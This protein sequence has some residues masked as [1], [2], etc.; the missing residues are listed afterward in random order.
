MKGEVVVALVGGEWMR[1]RL[2]WLC[3]VSCSSCS[4]AAAVV[5][6]AVCC[7]CRLFF[8][9][10]SSLI[11]FVFGVDAMFSVDMIG[12]RVKIDQAVMMLYLAIEL[13]VRDNCDRAIELIIFFFPD[14]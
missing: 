9:D 14:L 3:V 10:F 2:A 4:P 1:A 13:C 8:A 6:S 11:F 12:C 5:A 7:S